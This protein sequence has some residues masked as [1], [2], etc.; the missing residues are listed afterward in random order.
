V[1]EIAVE[2]LPLVEME[3][4]EGQ[5]R[6]IGL[7]MPQHLAQEVALSAS[8]P[9]ARSRGANHLTPLKGLVQIEILGQESGE[10]V[11]SALSTSTS[12]I[13]Y[14]WLIRATLIQPS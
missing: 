5:A 7:V 4:M 13:V 14:R 1:W 12:Q 2:R 11:V 3:V 6:V 8:Q 9:W 10:C